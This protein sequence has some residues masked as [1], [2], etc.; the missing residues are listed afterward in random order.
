MVASPLDPARFTGRVHGG[1]EES[2][3]SRETGRRVSRRRQP[4]AY[5]CSVLDDDAMPGPIVAIGPEGK[6]AI[7]IDHRHVLLGKIKATH[8]V[9]PV[10]VVEV[11]V[12]I[13]ARSSRL[14]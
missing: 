8:D 12:A 13:A 4:V 9:A 7:L 3:R 6:R 1:S 11:E 5:G 10:V 14:C 2:D